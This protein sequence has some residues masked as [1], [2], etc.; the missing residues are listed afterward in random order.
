LKWKK[1]ST[2]ITK[3][4]VRGMVLNETFSNISVAVEETEYPE[5]TT[6][7]SQA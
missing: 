4:E 5:K 3:E 2:I 6:D 1:K 7:L